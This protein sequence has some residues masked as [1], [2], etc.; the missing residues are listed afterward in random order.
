MSAPT[1]LRISREHALTSI[2]ERAE[3][4]ADALHAQLAELQRLCDSL[5]SH[6]DDLGGDRAYN[7]SLNADLGYAQ[8]ALHS[9]SVKTRA[10]AS[11]AREGLKR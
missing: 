2:A 5:P 10:V 8:T 1:R 7:W 11:H 6:I 3:A 4:I 9:L